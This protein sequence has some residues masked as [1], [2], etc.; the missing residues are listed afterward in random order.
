[1]KRSRVRVRTDISENECRAQT[2]KSDIVI[3]AYK[4]KQ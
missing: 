1:M 4:N 3:V 2:E